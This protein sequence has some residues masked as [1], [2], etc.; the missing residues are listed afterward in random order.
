MSSLS[1][2]LLLSALLL[3]LCG[4]GCL[5]L[6]QRKHF[7]TVMG[8]DCGQGGGPAVRMWGWGFVM[9]SLVPCVLRDGGGF[10]ALLWPLIVASGALAVAMTL[11][12]RPAVLRALKPLL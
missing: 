5:A 2:L 1:V 10:A 7:K 11:A 9:A 4:C 12:Y 6:A 3:A 8:N